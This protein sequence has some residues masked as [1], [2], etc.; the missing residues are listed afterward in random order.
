M[1]LQYAAVHDYIQACIDSPLSRRIVD[2]P[3]LQPDSARADPYGFIHVS[4]R[5]V[6]SA[7]D[8]Y[9]VYRLADV[10]KPGERLLS[11]DLALVGVDRN[12][13]VAI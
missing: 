9:K 13:A 3:L 10:F 6:A 11:K 12:D 7:K 5:L 8:V 1:L 4:S 2:D